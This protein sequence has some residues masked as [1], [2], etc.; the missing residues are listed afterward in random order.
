[1]TEVFREE[2]QRLSYPDA[3]AHLFTKIADGL[4]HAHLRGILHQDLKPANLLLTDEAQ[5]MLLDFNLSQD[6][7]LSD[8]AARAMIGGTLP[9]MPPEVIEAFRQSQP[10]RDCRSDIYSLGVI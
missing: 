8:S 7:K 5:P 2:L 3:V 9:Y 4:Q 1:Q 6:A 10:S